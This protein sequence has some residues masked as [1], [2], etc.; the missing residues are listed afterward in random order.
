M[1]V[2]VHVFLMCHNEQTL[3]PF[4]VRHYRCCFPKC[5]IT[6]FDNLSTDDSAKLAVQ[7]MCTVVPWDSPVPG[8]LDEPTLTEVKN[9]LWRRY[10]QPGTWVIVCDMDEW[11]MADLSDLQEEDALGTTMLLTDGWQMVGES[12]KAD[13]SD[14]SPDKVTKGYREAAYSKQVCFKWDA[15]EPNWG[16]GC[17]EAFPTGRVVCSQRTYLL[18]HM[19]TLGG[20]FYAAR[21]A[22][23]HPRMKDNREKYGWCGQYLADREMA[24]QRHASDLARAGKLPET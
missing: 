22:S 13:L 12:K 3:L 19:S 10:V 11:L 15:V 4:A 5:P 20:E 24:L 18:K 7:H 23:R 6:V 17:H 1:V 14:I 8:Q 9:T 21:N 2:R 16:H